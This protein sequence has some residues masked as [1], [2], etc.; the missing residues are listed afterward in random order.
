MKQAL[1]DPAPASA[2]Y[3]RQAGATVTAPLDGDTRADVI[4][5]GAG[6]TGLSAALHLAQ[7]GRD[8]VVLE[9][10][11]IARGGSGRA[12]GLVL[13]HHKLREA[14]LVSRFGHD[15]GRRLMAGIQE[16][17][18]LVRALI[19]AHDIACQLDAGG[20]IMAAHAPGAEPG[21][22]ASAAAWSRHSD[23]VSLLTADEMRA[24]TGS[25]LYRCGLID[26]RALA[27]NPH[28]Y[29]A[30]LARAALTHKVRIHTDSR[31]TAL[32]RHGANWR[33]TTARGY[34]EAGQVVVATDA[35]ADDL[36]PAIRR[37][38]LPIRL[39]QLVSAPLPPDEAA[40]IL[41]GRAIL[42]DSR[43]LYGGVRKTEDGRLQIS[44]DGPPTLRVIRCLPSATGM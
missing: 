5:V 7:R 36:I 23:Q 21:I 35:Y 37:A 20:W 12:L 25:S 15:A 41:P 33:A 43:R 38:V 4:V 6:I 26:R 9:A 40:A 13:P 34:A 11:S 22:R 31:V 18:R 42:T 16:G 39:Y 17:P 3:A 14:Q 19:D 24:A 10:G 32:A 8:V 30:G 2:T 44:A 29:T 1:N 27:L 28:A